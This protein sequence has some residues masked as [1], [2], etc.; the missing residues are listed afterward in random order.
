MLTQTVKRIVRSYRARVITLER[1]I[2]LL[3][4]EGYGETRAR[5]LLES[6]EEIRI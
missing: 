4:E 6:Q 1:A 3:A 2:Q 5:M